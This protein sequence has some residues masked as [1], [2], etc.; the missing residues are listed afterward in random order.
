MREHRLTISRFIMR[1][2]RSFAKKYWGDGKSSDINKM[3]LGFLID[4]P[5]C[6]QIRLEHLHCSNVKLSLLGNRAVI[7][8]K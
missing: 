3:Q 7:Y 1:F 4:L 5:T 6:S 2:L 8:F